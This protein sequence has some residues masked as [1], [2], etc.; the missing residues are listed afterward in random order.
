[1]REYR[2]RGLLLPALLLVLLL[3]GCGGEKVQPH[4]AEQ[5]EQ[6]LKADVFSG[7]MEQVEGDILCIL[8]GLDPSLVLDAAGYLAIDTS[9]SA[10]E[11][12]VFLMKDET[13]AQQAEAACRA[14]L[15]AQM[16]SYATYGPDQVPRLEQALVSRVGST[17]LL[18]VGDP[19]KL[20]A[21]VETLGT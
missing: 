14:R 1:M 5:V 11:V 18:A 21:A 2:R 13:G 4:S 10:D 9:V 15:Q 7:E 16:D 17:V 20:A 3:G 8:Y 6:L 19:D 12:A